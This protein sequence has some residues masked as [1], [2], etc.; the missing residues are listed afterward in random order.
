MT[1]P[2][3]LIE[4]DPERADRLRAALALEVGDD[5]IWVETLTDALVE[6]GARSIACI[7]L[8]VEPA[9]GARVPLVDAVTSAHPEVPIVVLSGADRGAI[10]SA[11]NFAIE[12]VG[13]SVERAQSEARYRAVV[14][15]LG[16][17][18]LV[19]SAS[20]RIQTCNPAAARILGVERDGML[21]HSADI[22]LGGAIDG[23]RRPLAAVDY[24]GAVALR[25]GARIDNFSMGYCRPDGDHRW[26]QVSAYPMLDGGATTPYGA[27]VSIRDVTA[28]QAALEQAHFQASLLDA[29]GQAVIATDP[30]GTLTYWN[31]SAERLY[32]WAAQEAVG[33]NVLAVVPTAASHAEAVAILTGLS[34]GEAWTGVLSANRRDGTVFPAEISVTPVL[35]DD[36]QFTAVIGVSTD[37][38]ERRQ[39]E[40]AM[41]Q[42]SAII[43]SSDDA[44]IGTMLDGTIL[45]WNPGAE[46]LYGYPA[47]EAVGLRAHALARDDVRAVHAE[48]FTRIARTGAAEQLETVS[49]RKDGTT[50]DISLAVS[51][52]RQHAGLITG[53]S[54]IGRDV[55]ARKHAERALMHQSL[56]DALTGLPNRALLEDRLAQLLSRSTTHRPPIA[57]LFLDLDEFKLV[58]E[59]FGHIAGD[60]I[61][62][63]VARRLLEA[64]RPED[65]VARFGGDEFVVVCEVCSVE[66]AGQLGRR[67]LAAVEAPFAL[68]ATEVIVTASIGLAVAGDDATPEG[69]LQDCDAAM[70]RAKARG[71]SRVEL[72]DASSRANAAER[73]HTTTALRRALERDELRV[74]FQPV[75]SISDARPLGVEALLRWQHPERGLVPPDDFIP[76]AEETGLIIPIGRWVLREALRERA[77]WEAALPRHAPLRLAVN[78]SARQLS[79]PTLV[80]E[81]AG[82]LSDCGA[83]PSSLILEVTESVLMQ[84]IE[85]LATLHALREMGISLH[86]DD[87]GTGYSSL[88]YLKTL[89]VDALK[90]DRSFVDGLGTTPEDLSIVTTVI[91]LARTLSLAV[92]AEGVETELQLGVLRELGC[93]YAQGYLFARPLP[94]DQLVAWLARTAPTPAGR[95]VAPRIRA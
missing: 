78:L 45:S 65:T 85:S 19:L 17:G 34:A 31:R 29:V 92:V 87:F 27:V 51:P 42:L 47:A 10:G 52:V 69:L 90:V 12:R 49:R 63:Q 41:R 28:I 14:E 74:F 32:G 22:P 83:A 15:S 5:V 7:V 2:I 30:D 95:D 48:V 88:A 1:L 44:V 75:V 68:D 57:V 23:N 93:D 82:A 43:Q 53:F 24:P 84:D 58:N 77:R 33:Q 8:E 60:K 79:D 62:I 61:L 4:V 89:P 70:Y 16:E 72:F 71:R 9:D 18:L 91:S 36:G 55:T 11:V 94:Y 40:D 50:F 26:L 13:A 46:R 66:A 56:H 73:L 20:G 39:T 21:G 80:A 3:L 67:L 76:L 37:V 54:V 38:T 59:G 86:V 6:L 35:D 25:T 81:V 64:L